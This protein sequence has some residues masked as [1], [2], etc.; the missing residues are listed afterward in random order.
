M[1]VFLTANSLQRSRNQKF[2]KNKYKKVFPFPEP[3]FKLAL[4][5]QAYHDERNDFSPCVADAFN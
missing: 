4:N 1:Y 2:Q 5:Q 3:M